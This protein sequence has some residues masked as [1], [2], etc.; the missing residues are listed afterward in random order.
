[1]RVY[2]L[3]RELG[4]DSKEVLAHAEQLEIGVKTALSGL[5]DEAAELLRL[6]F[7][8]VEAVEEAPAE[9]QV[10]AERPEF[11]DETSDLVI[12]S[13]VM[14][15][16]DHEETTSTDRLRQASRMGRVY[17]GKS[18]AVVA[19]EDEL[20]AQVQRDSVDDREPSKATLDVT[21]TADGP[22]TEFLE[23]R[24]RPAPEEISIDLKLE[25]QS[26]YAFV[27][28]VQVDVLDSIQ[29]AM[30]WWFGFYF[31]AGEGSGQERLE[32]SITGLQNEFHRLGELSDRI[33]SGDG[34]GRIEVEAYGRAVGIWANAMNA[35]GQG[36]K[37]D[38]SSAVRE[39]MS[40]LVE[41][42]DT[43][44]LV[45][46][47]SIYP[48]LALKRD[49]AER[50][51]LVGD[52]L[53]YLSALSPRLRNRPNAAVGRA[54]RPWYQSIVAAGSPIRHVRKASAE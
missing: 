12:Q 50:A 45:V 16:V 2:E 22:I 29:K 27:E 38:Q 8:P 18:E 6:A 23:G 11:D 14:G 15:R 39:G 30:R 48:D 10:V 41:A 36:I 43:A 40:L 7:A 20:E 34:L 3:A 13:P 25:Q 4:V 33:S 31:D 1:M 51:S 28:S 44:K 21:S 5:D 47:R 19:V 37:L 32:A 26:H 52:S 53:A 24:E 42:S 46:R 35:I 17:L 49:G 9:A 54:K